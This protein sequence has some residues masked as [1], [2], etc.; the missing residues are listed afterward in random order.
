[1][2]CSLNGTNQYLSTPVSSDFEFGTGDFTVSYAIKI[3]SFSGYSP[4]HGV[5]FGTGANGGVGLDSITCCWWLRVALGSLMFFRYDGT[6]DTENTVN[7]S[8]TTG[9][10]YNILAT[11]LG[12]SLR[13]F[14][15]GSQVGTSFTDSTSYNRAPPGGGTQDLYIGRC[16][17]GY[18]AG[19]LASGPGY[20][21]YIQYSNANYSEI[22]IWKAG[23]NDNEITSLSKG[24]TPDQIRP[25]SLTFYLPLVSSI[26]DLRGAK[27]IANV[28][29]ATASTHPR[30]IQ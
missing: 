24:F 23:L 18:P 28:N 6:T 9:V 3:N 14:I 19:E 1:M 26:Q 8:F 22:A 29:G 30:I 21:Y 20:R 15:D 4:F 10:T 12:T 13:L 16:L 7:F 2:A 17:T 11:R 25:Q 5:I 27:N